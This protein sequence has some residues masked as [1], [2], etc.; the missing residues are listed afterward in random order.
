MPVPPP[1]T[2]VTFPV[3]SNALSVIRCILPYRENSTRVTYFVAKQQEPAHLRAQGS[4]SRT[5]E[6]ERTKDQ[7]T[8]ARQPGLAAIGRMQDRTIPADD[9]AVILVEEIYRPQ[10]SNRVHVRGS[11]FPVTVSQLQYT[12]TRTHDPAFVLPQQ[13][14]GVQRIGREHRQV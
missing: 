14:N 3:I 1:V 12:T 9:P 2:I 4:L 6:R 8:H 11:R 5:R 13:T 10:P 7:L